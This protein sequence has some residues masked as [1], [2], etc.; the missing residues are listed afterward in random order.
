MNYKERRENILKVLESGSECVSASALASMFG[1]TRQIIVSDI[2]LLRANGSKI[3]STQRGY[4]ME[5][6]AASGHLETIACRHKPDQVAEEFYAVVDN[7]GHVL[8][9]FI[10]HPIYGQIT[11]ELNIASRYD[12]DEF[13]RKS[14]ESNASQLCELTEGNHFHVIRVPDENAFA[15]ICSRLADDGI[16]AE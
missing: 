5:N 3:V 7:G 2:A 4:L 8:N 1:V 15:R 10:E 13:I 12:A 9:V 6:A 11:A 16:L 14:S